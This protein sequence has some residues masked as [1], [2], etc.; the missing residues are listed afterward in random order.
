MKTTVRYHFTPIRMARIKRP[1]VTSFE[2]DVEEL[3]PLYVA[4]GN[5][6][7]FSLRGEKSLTVPQRNT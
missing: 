4:G 3:E 7:W 6:K 5:V 1:A 2:D